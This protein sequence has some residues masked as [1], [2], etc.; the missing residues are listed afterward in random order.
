MLALTSPL[1][2]TEVI[3]QFCIEQ[4]LRREERDRLLM[5]ALG[6]VPWYVSMS[7]TVS[8]LA[9]MG[10]GVLPSVMVADPAFV[11][12]M[13]DNPGVLLKIGHFDEVDGVMHVEI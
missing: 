10:L 7:L 4:E 12:E 8:Y 5:F 6:T 13:P 2:R 9:A 11:A 1:K 3:E